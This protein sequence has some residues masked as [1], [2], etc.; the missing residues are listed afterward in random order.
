M[1]LA[2]SKKG[3]KEE[4]PQPHLAVVSLHTPLE[5]DASPPFTPPF[6]IPLSCQ[7]SRSLLVCLGSTCSSLGSG[8]QVGFESQAYIPVKSQ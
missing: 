7:R 2:G 3:Q 5:L 4:A 1:A 6:L 8:L